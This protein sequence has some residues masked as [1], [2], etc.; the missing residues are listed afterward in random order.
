MANLIILRGKVLADTLGSSD[1]GLETEEEHY[2]AKVF[3]RSLVVVELLKGQCVVVEGK[4]R[5]SEKM[6]S[7]SFVEAY[8]VSID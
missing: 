7:L 3:V 1:F 2:V 8:K 4:L 5:A 6:P